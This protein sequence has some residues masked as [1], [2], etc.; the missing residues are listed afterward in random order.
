MLGGAPVAPGACGF[1]SL[2][3]PTGQYLSY[4]RRVVSTAFTAGGLG[5]GEGRSLSAN[6]LDHNASRA[7]FVDSA[8]LY[9]LEV[10]APL[11][12]LDNPH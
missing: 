6:T 12:I 7:P 10:V 8:K 5:A 4:D 3:S 2:W 11:D 9:I 1:I